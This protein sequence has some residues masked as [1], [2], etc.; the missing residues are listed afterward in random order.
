[1]RRPTKL[2]A[3]AA[4]AALAFSPSVRAQ[5]DL[6]ELQQKAI[7]EAVKKIAPSVVKIETSGGT[8]VVKAGPKGLLRRGSGPTTGLIVSPDGY[9]ISSAFNFANKPSTIRVA[10]PGLKERKVAR[11]VGTDS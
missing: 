4:L 7:Q 1:M 11:V 8:E 3:L 6:D 9:V 5:D 10:I 2:F